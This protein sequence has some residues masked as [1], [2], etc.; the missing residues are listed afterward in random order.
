MEGVNLRYTESICV[1]ITM[2]SPIQV[3]YANKI[4][5]NYNYPSVYVVQGCLSHL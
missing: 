1:N 5:R 2:Y 4:I 3:L